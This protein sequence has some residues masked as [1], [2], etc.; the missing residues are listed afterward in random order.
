MSALRLAVIGAGHWHAARH[1]DSFRRAGV[2]VVGFCADEPVAVA[3]WSGVPAYGNRLELLDKAEPELVLAM[4]RHADAPDVLAELVERR[5]PFVVEKPAATRAADLLP[6]VVAA[7]AQGQFATVPFINRYGSFWSQ[8]DRLRS[9]GML[10]DLGAARFRIVNGPPSR[11][12]ADGVPW[13]LDPLV[14][15]GGAMRNLG[16]HAV[17]AFLSIAKGDIE[18]VGCVMTDRQHRLAVEEHAI[19]LLRDEAGL[20]GVVEVGYSRPD[21]DGT[22]QEWCVAGSGAYVTELHDAVEVVTAEGHQQIASPD[23]MQRYAMFA[24]DVVGRLGNG[25]PPPVSLRDCWRAL[26]VIDRIYAVSRRATPGNS[27]N[28]QEQ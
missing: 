10:Q 27:P 14:S 7:E 1:L 3:R 17:D 28:R 2:E 9:E 8:L 13:V 24:A 12:L 18:V 21:D 16:P 22:D 15:G 4:P 6:H 26:D 25:E 5:V 11:Y 19:A 20:V 23:V